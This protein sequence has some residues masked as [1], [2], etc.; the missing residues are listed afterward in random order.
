MNG[1]LNHRTRVP[2]TLLQRRRESQPGLL[3]NI[4]KKP[5]FRC[6]G[7]EKAPAFRCAGSEKAPRLAQASTPCIGRK[8]AWTEERKSWSPVSWASSP[9]C[10]SCAKSLPLPCQAPRSPPRSENDDDGPGG[11]L[12]PFQATMLGKSTISLIAAIW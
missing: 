10:G 4:A 7:S 3:S 2:L 5:A 12:N 1:R 8:A 6:A 11:L 9:S